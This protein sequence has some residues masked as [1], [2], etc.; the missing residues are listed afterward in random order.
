MIS[1]VVCSVSQ[2]RSE[3]LHQNLASRV[4]D[5]F[6]FISIDN[7]SSPRSIAKVYNEGASR[8]KGDVLC[9]VHEDVLFHTGGWG[10]MIEVKALEEDCGVIGFIGSWYKS[11]TLSGWSTDERTDVGTFIQGGRHTHKYERGD[12]GL[13]FEPCVVADGFCLFVSRAKWAEHPFD[14]VLIKSFHVYDID[15]SLTLAYNG[16]RNYVC[17]C[18]LAEHLSMGGFGAEW[19]N[20]TEIDGR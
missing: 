1:F 12:T 3:V 2:N 4:G 5:V 7:S 17:H 19:I 15:F 8:A 9:F 16:M 14:E 18:I 13:D 20:A 6:E 10:K 11:K